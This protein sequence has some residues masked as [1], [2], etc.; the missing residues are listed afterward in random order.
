MKKLIILLFLVLQIACFA[1]SNLVVELYA[2]GKVVTSYKGE[3]LLYANGLG[4]YNAEFKFIP[5]ATEA[6]TLAN[7]FYN[8][9]NCTIILRLTGNTSTSSGVIE[10]RKDAT[11]YYVTVK[12]V[13]WSALKIY[14]STYNLWEV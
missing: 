11:Y 1:Q 10:L 3:I 12:G 9:S 7:Y 13:S 6:T 2:N 14:N 4:T 8:G 5:T